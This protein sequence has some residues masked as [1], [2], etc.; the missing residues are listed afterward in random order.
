MTTTLCP[1]FTS[2]K[3]GLDNEHSAIA[4]GHLGWNG[5]PDGGLAGLGISPS[6]TIRLFFFSDLAQVLQRSMLVY[7]DVMAHRKYVPYQLFLQYFLDTSRQ[8]DRSYA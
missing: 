7:K 1:D 8:F 4:F 3:G 6:K 5:Q 2:F